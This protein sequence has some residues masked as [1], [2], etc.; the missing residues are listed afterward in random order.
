ME[1]FAKILMLSFVTVSIYDIIKSFYKDNKVD[2]NS[3]VTAVLGIILA[4]ASGLDAFSLVGI[5]FKFAIVG[6]ILTGLVISK[7][8]KYVYDF[9]TKLISFLSGNTIETVR[10]TEKIEDN[11][12]G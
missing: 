7:G 10:I 3:I 1:Q 12:K 11:T 5:D 9:I 2:I 4:I 6:Q 8:S